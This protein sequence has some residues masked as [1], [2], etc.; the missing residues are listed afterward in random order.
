[1]KK[2]I[3]RLAL[4]LSSVLAAFTLSA[5]GGGGSASSPS[6][7]GTPQVGKTVS[8]VAAVGRPLIGTIYLTDSATP[9]RTVSVPITADGTFSFSEATLQGLKAPYLLKAIEPTGT[10]WY[11]FAATRGLANIN[12]LT[13]VAVAAATGSG[14]TESLAQFYATHDPAAMGALSRRLP[15]AVSDLTTALKP[16]LSIYGAAGADPLSGSY[17]VNQQGLDGFLDRLD[18]TISQGG[19]IISNRST[20]KE[21][22]SAPIANLAS[23]TANPVALPQPAPLTINDNAAVNLAVKGTLPTGV[24]IQSA[25]FT[26]QLPQGVNVDSATPIDAAAG[27]N[28]YAPAE[29]TQSGDKVTIT[30]TSLNGFGTGNFLTI[31]CNVYSNTLADLGT[32]DFTTISSALY[33]DIYQTQSLSG[34]SIVPTDFFN[35]ARAIQP[36]P[37]PVLGAQQP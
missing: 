8:G 35:P 13:T 4:A 20:G 23:G 29:V 32:A 37:I 36:V 26:L 10:T 7:L 16:L 14:D 22:F 9:S 3:K 31:R 11:S 2:T 24:A 34:L 19:V 6:A 1:M 21:V 27:A 17:I 12:P 5:C 15:A 28:I 30:L 33:S 25:T 18:F